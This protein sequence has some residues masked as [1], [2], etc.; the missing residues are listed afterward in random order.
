MNEMSKAPVTPP[1]G[2]PPAK[3]P[4][5][6]EG[7][8]ITSI[9]ADLAKG[10]RRGAQIAVFALV[11]TIAIFLGWAHF[12]KLDE[13]T[14]GLGRVIPASRTQVVQN[15]EGGI[16][17]EILA[18]EGEVVQKEQVL[19]RIDSTGFGSTLEEKQE[20]LAGLRAMGARLDA[21][22]SGE[23]PEFPADLRESH[24]DFVARE[25]ALFEARR[26]EY[27]A[28]A[29]TLQQQIEQK[30]LEI[31][32]YESEIEV[33]ERNLALSE[34]EL[35]L[36]R[37]SVREGISS[38]VEL[39][40]LQ[41]RVNELRGKLASAR[42]S[43]DRARSAL[44]E[45]E[46]RLDAHRTG[47]RSKVQTQLN[48]VRGR[49]AALSHTMRAFKDRVERRAVRSP[50]HGVVQTVNVTTIGQVVT[51]GMDLAEIIPIEDT[52]LVEARIRPSDVAFLRP[53][54]RAV[55]K[56]TAYD[57]TV[58][59]TLEG[60]LERISADTVEDD[61]G[62]TYYKINVRTETN[63]LKSKGERL[64]IIPGMVVEV[65]ILTG[66]KSVLQ[67]LLSPIRRMQR[68]ALRER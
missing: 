25:Q 26:Q 5:S 23:Q 57:F 30:R 33:T 10:P 43:L 11:A 38:R 45:A 16:V 68:Q 14:V 53:G 63:H 65:N 20:E 22:I 46:N 8:R 47:F 56:V 29:E 35:A 4:A 67:Y 2:K 28:T 7:R 32:G 15:L 50:V 12:A 64:P 44:R 61:Q 3:G 51:P 42:I 37:P 27:Q 55:V 41:Q 49:I 40:R 66:E 19:F 52:L 48:E 36:T 17:N 34:E 9:S 54:Q 39:I 18:R 13:V 6:E 62:N 59:G 21:E 31:K 1:A 60:K 58:Y 24:P